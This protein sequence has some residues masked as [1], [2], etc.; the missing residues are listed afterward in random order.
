MTKENEPTPFLTPQLKPA[1]SP[2][3]SCV[4]PNVLSYS[5]K[6]PFFGKR[7][8]VYTRPMTLNF[9]E[10]DY[11]GKKNKGHKKKPISERAFNCSYKNTPKTLK[12][13]NNINDRKIKIIVKQRMSCLL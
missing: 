9:N 5:V 13:K 2:I 3:I 7:S 11:P 1:S 6:S 10:L 12:V 8:F 4:T